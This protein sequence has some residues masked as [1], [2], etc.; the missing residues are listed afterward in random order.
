MLMILKLLLTVVLFF[1]VK[2]IPSSIF[3][4]IIIVGLIVLEILS[5][6]FLSQD[7]DTKKIAKGIEEVAEGNLSKKFTSKNKKYNMMTE[8][9]NKILNNYREA[10]SQISYSSDRMSGITDELTVA[11]KETNEAINEVAKSTES[12]SQGTK[13]EESAITQVLSMSGSLKDISTDTVKENENAYN[14]WEK[15][16]EAFIETKDSLGKLTSNM[17][18]RVSENKR[19]IEETRTISNNI[20]EI[21]E[22]VDV[23]RDISAK[24]N[25]L[26]LNA[27]IEAA[28]AGEYGK[29]FSVVANEIRTLAEMTD[30]STDKINSK[31]NEFG[32]AITGLLSD[33]QKTLL[34]EQEDSNFIQTTEES[35]EEV[36][37]SL[38]SIRDVLVKTSEKMGTQLD[39]TNMLNDEINRILDIST[40]TASGTEEIAASMEEQAA[41]MNEINN[42]IQYLG[43][44]NEEFNKVIEYHS[45]VTIDKELLDKIIEKN[46]GS[47]NEIRE[48]EDIRTFN[49]DNHRSIYQNVMNKNKDIDLIYLYDTKGKLLSA[50]ED[51]EDID[52]TNRAWFVGALKQDIY[53]SDFY[54]SYDNQKVSITISSQVKDM[55]NELV[56]ILGADIIIES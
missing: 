20:D 10:L 55:N 43:K 25:L 19:L 41:I 1:L 29:G 44:V 9:L 6:V 23:V 28:R 31:I 32:E 42:N 30:E 5:K 45:K 7:R 14:Q 17:S 11:I 16:N 8:N 49:I 39:K 56:G 35:F 26:S 53:V 40:E 15:A 48:N 4:Y 46:I 54:I 2:F 22:I 47:I 52:M 21:N 27:S 13:E 3:V 38:N 50:S 34:A 37:K 36:D 12:I 18:T 33:F 51:I 24:I